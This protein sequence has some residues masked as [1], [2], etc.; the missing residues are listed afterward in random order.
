MK[1]IPFGTN[2]FFSSFNRLTACYI[3]PYKGILIILDAGSGLYR[4]SEPIGQKLLSKHSKLHIFLSHC[5][6]DHTIGFYA[7][8]K[9]LQGKEVSV[10]GNSEKKVFSE[11]TKLDYFPINYSQE[12]KNFEWQKLRKGINEIDNYQVETIGLNH[13][14]EESLAFRFDFGLTYLTDGEISEKSMEFCKSSKLL[15]HEH[16]YTG[17]KPDDR[18]LNIKNYMQE[19]HAT[20]VG[21]AILAKRANVE[22]LILI[23][24]LPYVEAGILH[25][26]LDVAKSIFPQTQL[27]MDLHEIDF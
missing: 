7:A 13:R 22:K 4:L 6:I 23:H 20:T 5:H 14:G 8:F 12:Y 21:A 2:G 1:I 18:N 24:H 19:G 16:G 3:I 17:E 15:L 25:Q 9:L 26:Q 11:L 10:F 27:A